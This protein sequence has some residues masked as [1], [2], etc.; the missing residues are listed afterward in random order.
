M[1]LSWEESYLQIL[2]FKG[3]EGGGRGDNGLEFI[4]IGQVFSGEMQL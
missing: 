4:T 3:P 1:C 2:S